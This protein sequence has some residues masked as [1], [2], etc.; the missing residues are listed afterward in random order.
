MN[1]VLATKNPGKIKELLELAD[2]ATVELEMAPDGFDAEET[3]ASFQENAIIKA[4]V[5]ALMTGKFALADD[6]GLSVDALS[7]GPGINSARYCEGTDADRRHKLLTE[8][9]E[10]PQEKR[11]ASFVCAMALCNAEGQVIHTTSGIWRGKI[12]V[13][14]RGENGFGY[15]P[16]FYLLDRDLTAAELSQK[17]KNDLSHRGKAWRAMLSKLKQWPAP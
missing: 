12:G 10:V 6:S 3:G 13:V 4:R 8:L 14:E 9:K 17:E 15:D 5:A 7:G 16:I 2:D 1:L 11:Q